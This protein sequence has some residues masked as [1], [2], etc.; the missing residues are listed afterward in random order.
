MRSN[1]SCQRID[2]NEVIDDPIPWEC[3]HPSDHETGA[4][5][6]KDEGELEALE[7]TRHFFKEGDVFYFFGSCSPGHVDF[8][9]MA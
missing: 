6:A 8:E 7:K 3:I 5:E 4:G 1:N 9:E 2:S